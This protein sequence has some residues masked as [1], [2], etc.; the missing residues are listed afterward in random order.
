MIHQ[1]GGPKVA[2]K[3]NFRAPQVRARNDLHRVQEP[4]L[5]NRYGRPL[6]Q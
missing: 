5:Q 3:I 6:V 1:S 2:A 4:R